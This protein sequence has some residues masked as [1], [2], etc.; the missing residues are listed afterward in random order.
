M[1]GRPRAPRRGAGAI[2]AI[3]SPPPLRRV[4]GW[5]APRAARPYSP[6]V[7]Q[8]SQQSRRNH[9]CACGVFVGVLCSAWWIERMERCATAWGGRGWGLIRQR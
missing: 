8:V 6:D 1:S 5:A 2:G 7:S 4:D 9:A 3:A